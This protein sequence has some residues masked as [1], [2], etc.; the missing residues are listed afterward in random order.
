M[1]NL[2]GDGVELRRGAGNEEDINASAGQLQRELSTDTVRRA[3][4]EG[5]ATFGTEGVKLYTQGQ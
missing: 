1:R 2:F 5:P 3:G 4:H